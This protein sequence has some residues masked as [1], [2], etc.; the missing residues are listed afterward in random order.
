MKTNLNEYPWTL[1][2][3]STLCSISTYAGTVLDLQIMK[4]SS[5]IITITNEKGNAG[6]A[7]LINLNPGINSWHT[8]RV[9]F[10]GERDFANIHL[11]N[12]NPSKNVLVLNEKGLEIKIGDK[13]NIH[14]NIF[15]ETS[16]D[17]VKTPVNSKE[18]VKS[19]CSNLISKRVTGSGSYGGAKNLVVAGLRS[20]IG[21]AAAES[22]INQVKELEEPNGDQA[23]IIV[24]A[25]GTDQN[26]QTQITPPRALIEDKFESAQLTASNSDMNIKN[27]TDKNYLAGKWYP[28]QYQN[29]VSF[30]VILPNM[31]K[32]TVLN[33]YKKRVL[34][35]MPKEESSLVYSVAFDLSQFE[36]G[37]AHGTSLPGVGWSDISS[38]RIPGLSGPDGFDS[39]S[40]ISRSGVMNSYYLPRL[41]ATMCGGF[42]RKHGVFRT[43]NLLH[44][45]YGFMQ[46]GVVLS[47]LNSGLATLIMYKNGD[48][49]IK[50]WT[51]S[52]NS[53]LSEIRHARQNGVPLI[54]RANADNSSKMT[55]KSDDTTGIPGECVGSRCGNWSGSVEGNPL[56]QRTS[57]CL[58]NKN[59]KKFLVYSYFSAA[60]PS[61]M[62]R[63]LQAYQCEYAVHLDMNSAAQGYMGLYSS[64][65]ESHLTEHPVREMKKVDTTLKIDGTELTVPRY[66]GEPSVP[67]FFY[68]L[69]KEK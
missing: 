9:Q 65:G 10:P 67:D 60:R 19:I 68:I 31:L 61:A 55:V 41:A 2:I 56:S 6:K 34:D 51:D 35:L 32:N 12:N 44:K 38:L 13:K 37:W 39:L 48:I 43:G 3:L 63:V 30:S 1:A 36:M 8:L 22:I 4:T 5:G 66:V 14:C 42:Q 64:N 57:A 54:E 21:G 50:T 28:L 17:S 23:E 11:E 20:L 69:R 52:D 53:K 16:D 33:S 45:Y 59:G 18:P 27:K 47:K 46:E 7:E 49:E 40:P 62:A 15:D 58:I 25:N 29:G 24:A 26:E